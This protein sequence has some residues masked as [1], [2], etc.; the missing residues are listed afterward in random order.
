MAEFISAEIREG[1]GRVYTIKQDDGTLVEYPSATTILKVL[2]DPPGLTWFKN[3]FPNAEQY[4]ARRA[5]IGTSCHFHLESRCAEQVPEHVLEFEGV[6]ESHR[7]EDSQDAIDNI[8]RKID[9][10]LRQNDYQTISMEDVVHSDLLR[11]A[12]RVDWRGIWNGKRTILDLKTSK[13]FHDE[14]KAE[15]EERVE[16]MEA[17]DGKAPIQ[18]TCK[19]ALQ[20]SLY[21]QAYKECF[22]WEAEQLLILRVN[23]GNKPEIRIQPDILEDVMIVREMFKDE[24]NI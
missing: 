21:K 11:V 16:Y 22:D 9:S 15:Y 14:T 17:H 18:F 2:P 1:I 24:Y 5:M 23:E 20:L 10:V 6:D 7:D 19:H 8:C 3:N 4:T 12:G 13:A